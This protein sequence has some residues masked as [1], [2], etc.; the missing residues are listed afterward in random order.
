M[1]QVELK[2]MYFTGKNERHVRNRYNWNTCM[3]QADLK[4][5]YG[6]LELKDMYVTG[7]TERC[8]CC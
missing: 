1:L 7:R 3:L 5:M 2:N 8:V 6:T 4:D